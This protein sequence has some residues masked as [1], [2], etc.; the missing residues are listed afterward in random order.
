MD[1]ALFVGFC[2]DLPAGRLMVAESAGALERLVGR[3]LRP[4]SVPEVTGA[5]LTE[6]FAADDRTLVVTVDGHEH[7]VAVPATVAQLAPALNAAGAPFVADLVELGTARHLRLARRERRNAGRITVQANRSLGFP[8]ARTAASFPIGATLPRV[9]ASFFRSGGRRAWILPMGEPGPYLGTRLERLSRLAILLGPN[10]QA[11]GSPAA[12]ALPPLAG[13]RELPER[14]YGPAAA[15]GLEEAFF[16]S[17]PDLAELVSPPPEMPAAMLNASGSLPEL[18]VPCAT[19]AATRFTGNAGRLPPPVL[20]RASAEL[21]ARVVRHLLL[22]LRAE[23]PDR[24]LLLSLPPGG[25]QALPSLPA[26]ALE[27]CQIAQPWLVTPDGVDLPS[28]L[29]PPEAV[30][31]GVVAGHTLTAGCFLSAANTVVPE[32]GSLAKAAEDPDGRTARFAAGPAGITLAADDTPSLDPTGRHAA[33]RR[34]TAL[35]LRTA[36]ILGADAVFEPSG[37]RLW[38]DVE[39]RLE[40]LLEQLFAAGGL[41]GRDA[42][43]AFFARCGRETMT[44]ADIA[45]GRV[46]AEVGFAPALP[47]ERVQVRLALSQGAA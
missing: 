10:A 25:E 34:L 21:W 41:R 7:R 42:G 2:P 19:P 35:L 33:V 18:F 1:V 4:D 31:A 29:V 11:E 3:G 5:A 23:A 17:L 6:P 13:R 16:L 46:V 30:L 28:G 26:E 40:L 38:R 8:V 20:D 47:V 22:W 43:E 36:A 24:M 32:A 14:W 44:A 39:I 45:L 27:L 9:V 15:L 12:L 37:E